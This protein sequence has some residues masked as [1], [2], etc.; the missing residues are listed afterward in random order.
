[1]G[2]NMNN[3]LCRDTQEFLDEQIIIFT[4]DLINIANELETINYDN[5]TTN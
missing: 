2:T 1:M 3:N 5:P 4:D